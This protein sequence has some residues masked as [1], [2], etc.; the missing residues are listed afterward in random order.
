MRIFLRACFL[1]A[2]LLTGESSCPAAEAA[3]RTEALLLILGDQ[4]SAY[5]QVA[6]LVAEVD[7]LKAANPGVP[8]AVLIDGDS[9]EYG[10]VVARRSE[11]VIDLALFA[12][13]AKRAPTILNL[14]N[15]E[16]D[17]YDPAAAVAKL[18][19][20]GVVVISGNA[21]DRNTGQPLAPASTLLRLGAHT[22]TVVGV[23]TDQLSTFRLAVRP[24]LDLANPVVWAKENFPAL[25]KDTGLPIVLSH[26]GIR[27]DREML[28]LVPAG[29]LFAG[30]HDHVRFTHRFE[31]GVRYFHSGSWMEF[32]S[33]AKLR[34]DPG[35]SF[36]WEVEQVPLDAQAPG[37]PALTALVGRV[38]AE[39]LTP[40]DTA[41]VG[42][43]PRAL[44]VA[45][46]A[47]FAAAAVARAAGADTAFIGNTTFGGGLPAGNVTQIEFDACVRFDGPIFT[48]TVRGARLRELVAAANLG[49][50]APFERRRGEFSFAAGQLENFADEKTYRIATTDWGAKNTA[51]YFGEP[52]L[53]WQEHPTV[54]LKAAVRAA[55]SEARP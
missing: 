39:H 50:E 34:R 13:L 28:P 20:V 55:W 3:L 44:P 7:R 2:L 40:K 10:N 1:F 26:A 30:A 29:T 43:L 19:A 45:E 9:F 42:R 32:Y 41:V 22:A 12:A 25:L 31:T 36:Y 11:A 14:G 23:M 6:P 24:G 38:R 8:F 15:H 37:D 46:A 16:P 5:D 48:A 18:R 53:A 54:K 49:P 35:G 52:A 51:R 47:R 4:H 27:A 33:L 21:R 17:F